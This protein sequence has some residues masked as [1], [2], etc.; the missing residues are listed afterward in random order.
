MR[1]GRRGCLIHSKIYFKDFFF[2][3]SEHRPVVLVVN[4]QVSIK[5]KTWW[6]TFFVFVLEKTNA[7]CVT[8]V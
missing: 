5:I 7:E 1:K 8:P 2:A 3:S 4:E 6:I